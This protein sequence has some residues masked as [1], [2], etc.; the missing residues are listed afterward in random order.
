M[1]SNY[2]TIYFVLITFEGKAILSL[3]TNLSHNAIDKKRKDKVLPI[4]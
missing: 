2:W 3:F 4:L 1:E